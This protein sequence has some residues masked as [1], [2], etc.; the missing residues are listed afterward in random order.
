[1]RHTHTQVGVAED[2]RVENLSVNLEG[3]TTGSDMSVDE[4][5]QVSKE[6]L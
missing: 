4:S 5:N 2:W 3:S 1:M 6:S